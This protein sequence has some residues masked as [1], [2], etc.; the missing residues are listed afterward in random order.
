MLRHLSQNVRSAG[1]AAR[2]FNRSRQLPAIGSIN[3]SF[4]G[5]A[6]ASTDN[7]GSAGVAFAGL[8]MATCGFCT[9]SQV[10]CESTPPKVKV[11]LCQLRVG[12]NKDQNIKTAKKAIAQAAA[13][14]AKLISLPEVWNGPYMTSAFPT[15]AEPIPDDS[16]D[17]DA[18]KS[19]STAM[20]VEAAKQHQVYLV[21]G[22]ISERGPD[23]NVYNTSVI[24]SPTGDILGKHRKVHLFDIDVPGKI[25]FR[26][27]DTLTAGDSIT[28]VD[29]EWGKVGI[30]ICYDIRFPEQAMMMR[31]QDCKILMYPGAF[32]TT[33]GPLHWEL[34]QRSRAVDN[35]C[36][37]AT[38]SP[39]RNT[40]GYQAWGH[41]TV[42]S[43]WGK[44]VATT[45]HDPDIVFA[46]LDLSEVHEFRTNVPV[47]KQKR[48][49]MYKLQSKV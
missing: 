23:G 49:D 22:S 1:A 21:G 46:E 11:A 19:P 26:E 40:E 15:Y 45:G 32:N 48:H 27:S 35:Q 4:H 31:E 16:Q 18:S 9:D 42:V 38:I 30:A 5:N 7:Y 13:G 34:L 20:M 44:I 41:S 10:S 6:N 17:I 47:S 43:P 28:V 29:T 37:V 25:T 39:A 2:F 36:F 3:F 33:T 24:I 14:G 8:T 12:D